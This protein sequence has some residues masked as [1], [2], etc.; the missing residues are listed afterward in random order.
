MQN[1]L[2]FDLESWVYPDLPKFL[3]LNSKE[4][5]NLDDGYLNHSIEELLNILDKYNNK[6]TFFVVTQQLEWKKSLISEIRKAGHEIAYHTYDHSILFSENILT[7]QL[8]RSKDFINEFKPSGVRG[9]QLHYKNSY[10]NILKSL[11]FEYKSN[12]FS[13]ECINNND[14]L[15]EI[16]ISSSKF[17][18]NKFNSDDNYNG[19]SIKNLF[20]YIF[21]GSPFYFP[22]LPNALMFKYIEKINNEGKFFNI[23]FHNWQIIKPRSNVNLKLLLKNPL[24]FNYTLD[25]KKKFIDFIKKYNSETMRSVI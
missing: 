17:M 10:D 21:Y 20:K 24:Y 1:L 2:S 16:Y 7:N 9:P 11:N 12:R 23:F 4:R 13:N 14:V 22:M 5:E 15:K 19:I 6:A 25:I 8:N 18:T 3:E